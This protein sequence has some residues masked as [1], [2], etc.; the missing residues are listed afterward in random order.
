MLLSNKFGKDDTME[1]SFVSLECI[2]MKYA[3][4]IVKKDVNT[5][6]STKMK[7]RHLSTNG[8][9]YDITSFM[10]VFKLFNQFLIVV[11]KTIKKSLSEQNVPSEK[12]YLKKEKKYLLSCLCKSFSIFKHFV[13]NIIQL[14]SDGLNI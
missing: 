9:A 7:L 11:N 1:L 6:S 4:N 12:K 13:Y 3:F 5:F 8:L 2:K 10:D 14:L